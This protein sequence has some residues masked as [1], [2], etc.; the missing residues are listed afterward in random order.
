MKIKS[1][2]PLT[3]WP[4]LSADEV[5]LVLSA[6]AVADMAANA[7]VAIMDLDN[8]FIFFVFG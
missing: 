5:S 3:A 2:A 8:A 6:K 4:T 1:A 7:I